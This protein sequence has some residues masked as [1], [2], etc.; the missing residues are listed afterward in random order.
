MKQRQRDRFTTW[1]ERNGLPEPVYEH[2]FHAVREW[3][4]DACWPAWRV[5]LEVEGG[6]FLKGG[7][8]HNRGAGFRRDLEKY[9]AAVLEGW[10]LYRCLPEQLCTML[11]LDLLKVALSD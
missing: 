10:A 4:F 6:V 1:C 5:A 8:R 3:R 11:L 2:R 9:N 7:G